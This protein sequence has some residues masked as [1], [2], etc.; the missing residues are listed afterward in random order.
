M[1]GAAIGSAIWTNVTPAGLTTT[2]LNA[3]EGQGSGLVFAAGSNGKVLVCTASC[4]TSSA[5]WSA[6]AAGTAGTVPPSGV[7]FNGV[8]A[9]DGNHVYAAGSSGGNGVIWACSANCNSASTGP[10]QVPSPPA[11]G[12]GPASGKSAWAAITPVANA[13]VSPFNTPP[14]LYSVT[15]IGAN[16]AWAVGAG[17]AIF[18]CAAN[19]A[20]QPTAWVKLSPSFPTSNTLFGVTSKD[21]THIWAVGAAGTI[22]AELSPSSVANGTGNAIGELGIALNPLVWSQTQLEGN[23]VDATQ[24]AQ[25]FDHTKNAVA[26][27][28]GLSPRPSWAVTQMTYL[29]YAARLVASTAVADNSCSP[30]HVKEL[31][32]AQNELANGDNEF[33]SAHYDAAVDHYKKAWEHAQNVNGSP[34]VGPGITVD[35]TGQPILTAANMVPLDTATSTTVT[36]TATGTNAPQVALYEI[37]VTGLLL[38][39][40][41]LTIVEDGTTTI[42]T[43]PLNSGW[44]A[45]SPLN[46]GAWAAGEHHSFVFTVAFPNHGA[47]DN[48]YQGKSASLNFVWARS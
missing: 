22:A 4:N 36:V 45:V 29:D 47:S 32:A 20:T 15:A 35:P 7:T 17:G 3:V 31:T 25:F 24:Y 34:C 42:Y 11:V 1:R 10:A 26:D 39:A 16:D 28:K 46:L 41:T 19:C 40:L 21:A 9:A 5:G 43:G 23:H 13:P 8:W 44:T 6:L 18:Y 48:S 33:N 27:V 14:V 37:N 38:P 2:A 30:Q 12:A